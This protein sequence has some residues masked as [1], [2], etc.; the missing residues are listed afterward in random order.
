MQPA[1]EV[2]G[3][4][5]YYVEG[6]TLVAVSATTDPG[7][8][9]G[10]PTPLF[11]EPGLGVDETAFWRYDAAEDGEKFAV[12]TIAPGKG[13]SQGAIRVVENWYEEFQDRE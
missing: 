1:V 9:T 13:E 10:E 5:L 7:C 6:Y 12:V 3:R 11:S 2:D 4:E 8:S